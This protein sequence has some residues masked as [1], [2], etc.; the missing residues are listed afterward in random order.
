MPTRRD[1]LAAA[2]ALAAARAALA[3]VADGAGKARIGICTF[4]CHQHWNA[5][6]QKHPEVRFTDARSFYDYARSLGAEGVQTSVAFLDEAQARTVQA[7]VAETG[8]Y[9]EG[10]LRLPQDEAGL[11]EFEREVKIT[12]AAGAT[13]ARAVLMGGRRYEVFKSLAE[14]REFR[15]K[16]SKRLALVE[17]V[18]RKH[19]LKLA[20]ENH[21]DLTVEELTALMR[22]I[23]SEWIGVLVDTGNNI[24]LLD[25]P[26]AAVDALAPYALSVHFKDMAL[27]PDPQ[28]FLLSEI[29]CGQGYLDLPRIV[30]ALRKANPSIVFNLEMATR[31]PLKVPCLMPEY[32][33][34]YPEREATHLSVAMERV[35]ANATQHDP[36]RVSGKP[37]EEILREEE[38]HNR[39]SLSW[40]RRS[41]G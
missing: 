38:N 4:S 1:I 3:K 11:A 25:E 27:Q 19:G 17:P 28:G 8:G 34:T 30:S 35:D 39:A 26:H 32:W 37:R 5:V 6:R 18:L 24:A 21:K 31:D 33:V 10:D 15:T 16:A 2:S 22:G 20:V 12:R 14:F 41:V 7:H 13:V 40:M 29:P 9:F 23:G 36:P